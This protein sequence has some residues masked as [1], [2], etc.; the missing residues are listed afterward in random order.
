METRN[1]YGLAFPSW[2][3]VQSEVEK[4]EEK[5]KRFWDGVESQNP[6]IGAW[7]N[8]TIHGVMQDM[9]AKESYF[10]LL[11][12]GISQPEFFEMLVGL[13]VSLPRRGRSPN[14]LSGTGKTPK[15]L[16][17]LAS[18]LEGAAG[19]LEKLNNHPLLRP[20]IWIQTRKLSEQQK[21]SFGLW[22]GRLPVLLRYYAAF[23][24]AHSKT[25]RHFVRQKNRNSPQ[26]QVLAGV[27][28]LVRREAGRPMLSDLA[29]VLS[30]AA[31][32][33]GTTQCFD[34]ASLKVLDYRSRKA[35]SK[36]VTA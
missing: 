18:R 33:A 6:T 19:E 32:G 4:M 28:D 12:A 5:R 15:T 16:A 25:M 13:A 20:D 30:A 9:V 23:L 3:E 8:I 34:P 24:T 10:R 14:W 27:I 22:F 31:A 21:K 1:M 26:A 2:E 7:R 35:R 11:R 36:N 17:S 29:N